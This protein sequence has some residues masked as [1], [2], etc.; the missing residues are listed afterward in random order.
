MI[1]DL[2][3]AEDDTSARKGKRAPLARVELIDCCQSR[4]AL[5]G[6]DPFLG[7]GKMCLTSEMVSCIKKLRT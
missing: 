3:L 2:D 6:Q 5:M 1:C 7:G 4:S